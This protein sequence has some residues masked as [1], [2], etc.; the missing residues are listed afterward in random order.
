MAEVNQIASAQ[1]RVLNAIKSRS[2][3]PEAL[4]SLLLS[5]YLNGALQS[6]RLTA[7]V[8][9]MLEDAPGGIPKDQRL[10]ALFAAE[11]NTL[12]EQLEAQNT[13]PMIVS[14]AGS[15]LNGH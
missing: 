7:M 10:D 15:R 14:A 4:P 13:Q 6:C 1:D 3:A 2:Y 11:L 5:T 8:K 12:A 9:F